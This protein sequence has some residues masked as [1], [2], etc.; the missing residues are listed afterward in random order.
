[1]PRKT[2][3]VTN[4]EQ[5]IDVDNWSIG[6][7]DV[8]ELG[9]GWSVRKR[10]LQGGLQA[11]VTVIEIDNGQMRFTVIPTRGMGIWKAWMGEA[12]LGW[13]SP[14][15]G[16]IHPQHVPL[17]EPGGL[18]WLDG[19]DEL[20]VRCGLA[21]NGA[22]EFD[23][24]NRL[25]YPLHGRIA[26][27]PAYFVEISI[28]TDTREIAVLGH[29]DET[30]FHFEK[31]RLQARIAT[32][33]GKNRL[34]IRDEVRNLS[35][36]PAE[37]QM[38]YHVNFGTPLLDAGSQLVVPA[39]TI[40]PRNPH[41]AASLDKW[42]NYLGPEP[43]FPE[44]AYFFDLLGDASGNTRTL[45]K[46][47]HGTEGVSLLFNRD[48]LPCFTQWKNTTS[49][50]DGYVTGIEPGTNFPNPRSFEAEHDR[51]VKL[52]PQGS[53]VFDLAIEWHRD[54]A[55]VNTAETAV[56]QLQ[57]QAAPTIHS[58]ALDDWCAP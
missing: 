34:S 52:S 23:E 54:A 36:S 30:R 37:M 50:A 49:I 43:G 18:G 53:Q 44:E 6:P 40:V 31:L 11:G 24:N 14:V 10:T 32:H 41:A 7:A 42:S 20:L 29:V 39:K 56:Q 26:N 33:I 35:D 28:D 25:K 2:W 58:E 48:Q 9:D 45:L 8:P 47:A 27:R 5:D 55:G 51:V 38:L 12:T 16:P 57:S 19:F 46:N 4:A 22:P 17:M 1:M 13:Q 15:R 3:V 21:S